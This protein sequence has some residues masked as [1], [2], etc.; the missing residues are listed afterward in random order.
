V[1][2]QPAKFVSYTKSI[3]SVV[4]LFLKPGTSTLAL[5]LL[6]L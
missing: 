6:Y 2:H 4:F 5:H 1:R 3:N